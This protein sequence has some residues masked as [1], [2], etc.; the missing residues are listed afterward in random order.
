MSIYYKKNR[1]TAK[2]W[3]TAEGKREVAQRQFIRRQLINSKGNLCALCGKPIENM[4]DC[5]ID[6]IIPVS[7]GG[8]TTVENCQL[9]HRKCNLKR[10]NQEFDQ[11]QSI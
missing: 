1:R 4:K 7:K 5:T 2:E 9:A 3:M 10:G 8:L 11:H 6:H